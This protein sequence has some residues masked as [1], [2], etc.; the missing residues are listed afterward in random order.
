MF[1][2]FP[3]LEYKTV[4]VFPTKWEPAKINNNNSVNLNISE[5]DQCWNIPSPC[6]TVLR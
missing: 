6:V 2:K 3:K 4:E 5:T 1:T